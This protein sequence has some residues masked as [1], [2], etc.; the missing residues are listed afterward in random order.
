VVYIEPRLSAEVKFLGRHKGGALRDAVPLSVGEPPAFHV[1]G[2][3]SC[4][5]DA[6]TATMDAEADVISASSRHPQFAH[7]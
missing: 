2:P 6:V 5:S 4:D 1:P 3:W 7:R